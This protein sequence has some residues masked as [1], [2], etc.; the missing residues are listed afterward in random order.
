MKPYT[1]NAICPKCETQYHAH[2]A[3]PKYCDG[4]DC[5]VLHAT[6]E[7]IRHGSEITAIKRIPPPEH[8]HCR[9]DNCGY[10]WLMECADANAEREI[11]PTTVEADC[12]NCHARI[13]YWFHVGPGRLRL[14]DWFLY[15]KGTS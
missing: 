1:S 4:L 15:T 9:C 5:P 12:P 14:K 10:E 11:T 3:T 6:A 2:V 13:S 8:L 7:T